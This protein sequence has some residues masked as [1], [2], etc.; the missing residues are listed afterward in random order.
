MVIEISN[1]C[2]QKSKRMQKKLRKTKDLLYIGK[3]VIRKVNS[4][5]K[6]VTMAQIDNEKTFDIVRVLQS[7]QTQLEQL[8][9]SKLCKIAKF[10][11]TKLPNGQLCK[12]VQ[13]VEINRYL[14]IPEAVNFSE[15]EMKYTYG[16][17]ERLIQAAKG[18]KIGRLNTTSSLN[19]KGEERKFQ[20]WEDKVL[21]RQY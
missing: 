6:N 8:R 9:V 15:E 20:N 16:S 2:N 1:I 17:N 13:E 4:M 11:G 3:T 10:G 14:G 7:V 5:V 18:H 21:H 19:E 12:S